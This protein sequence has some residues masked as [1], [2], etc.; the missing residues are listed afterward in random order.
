MKLRTEE[1]EFTKLCHAR[2]GDVV[3]LVDSMCVGDPTKAYLVVMANDH[4]PSSWGSNGLY[5]AERV[6]LIDVEA[7]TPIRVPHLSSR[8]V[9]Y[10]NAEVR[11]N[12]HEQPI[13]NSGLFFSNLRPGA[14]R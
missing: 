9:I 4:I 5:S 13:R 11:L 10:R 8:V 1:R 6:V 12:R 14:A 7:G 3:Q 2:P